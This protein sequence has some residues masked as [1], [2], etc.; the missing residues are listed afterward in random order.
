VT[1]QLQSLKSWAPV[2]Y[3]ALQETAGTY[4]GLTTYKDLSELVQ[5]R[6]GVTTSS[7]MMNWIGTLLEQIALKAHKDGDAPL[8]ALCVRSDGSIGDGYARAI[9]LTTGGTPDDLEIRAAED[10][11]ACYQKYASNVPTDGGRPQLTAQVMQRRDRA[12]T[13]RSTAAKT[14]GSLCPTCFMQMSVNGTCGNCD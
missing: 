14:Y 12:S 13:R 11:L 10:R 2:G 3:A 9:E 4:N 8:A 5:E 7:L 6:S 1:S